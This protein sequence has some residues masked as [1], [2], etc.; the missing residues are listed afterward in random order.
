MTSSL[1]THQIGRLKAV[2]EQQHKQLR[3][4]I[5]AELLRSD[6]ETYGELAGRVHDTGDESVADLLADVS[7]AVIGNHVQ[8]VRA[9]ETALQRIAEGGYGICIDCDG[10]IDP[11]R[12]ERQ[13]AA[14][15]CISCQQ[16]YET[17]H[18][19]TP[20]PKL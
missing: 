3:A 20:Y 7:I 17:T 8:E 2:L 11:E 15:R 13:P 12:L 18:P 5:R 10:A 19:G 4:A 6:A 1:T 9:I 16:R 14:A